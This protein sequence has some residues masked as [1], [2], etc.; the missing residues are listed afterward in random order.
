MNPPMLNRRHLLFAVAA[1]AL[2]QPA[3]S[4]A[5]ASSAKAQLDVLLAAF[6]EEEMDRSPELV[7][8]LGLDSG[9]RAG[10]KAALD[11]RSL[12]ARERD[13]ADNL[14]RLKRL[15]VIDRAALT[16]E[17]AVNYDTIAFVMQNQADYD[18]QF[19]FGNGPGDPFVIT[20]QDGAYQGLPDFLDSQHSIE[21]T[22]D[23]EAYLS[24]LAAFAV[25]MDQEAEKAR[26]DAGLG[27]VAPD[28]ILDKTLVQ[29]NDLRAA[30]AATAPLVQSLVRRA[31]DKGL[32][33][34]W[35]ARASAIYADK[36]LPALGRQVDLM[37]ELK[38]KANH[39]SGVWAL[40]G[41]AAYYAVS[42]EAMTT[43]ELT[44]DEI[45]K[46]GVELVASLTA[47]LDTRLKA[48]GLADGT[49]GARLRT[50]YDDPKYRYPNTDAGKDTLLAD[51]NAKVAVIQ[52][53]LPAWFKTLPKTTVAIRRVPAYIEAGAAGGYYQPG[54]LDGSRPGA[55]YINLRDTAETPS[56]SLPTLTY[57]EAIPG[58]HLQ[59]SLQQEAGL[60]LIRKVVWF[61]AYGEGWALYAEQLA[62]EMGMYETDPMGRI[63]YLHDALF[64]ALRLV[65]DTGLHQQKWTREQAIK[66]YVETLGDQE[67]GAVTEVERYCVSPGQACS[68]MIGKLTWLRLRERAKTAL[69]LKFDIREFHDAGLL[70]G[71]TPLTV[72]D[73]VIADYTKA[74]LA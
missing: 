48:Q 22:A 60:P 27:V 28:F 59:L 43:T 10:A 15:E 65:V 41:G 1:T 37:G 57:H 61:S 73:R 19:G 35:A 3:S 14:D 13:K 24:R 42:L 11:D 39:A 64:R 9:A 71:P 30:P 12:A 23:A 46:L 38:A 34:D 2:T 62:D 45:H 54:T 63:G 52:A 69:G 26:H 32:P 6:I 47:E 70:P 16:G 50:L 25:A 40:P 7:T 17:D 31:K 68:Y 8:T 72:L 56:W 18:R 4:L 53:K 5:A 66:Y 58:H 55:Y 49:V 21:T 20:Q 29:L 36:V 74:K 51:L 44:P 33:G 67:A